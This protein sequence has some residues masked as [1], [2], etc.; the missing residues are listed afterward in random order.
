MWRGAQAL[1]RPRSSADRLGQPAQRE[2]EAG[3]RGF[4]PGRPAYCRSP[5]PRFYPSSSVAFGPGTLAEIRVSQCILSPERGEVVDIK[6]KS[7]Y[8]AICCAATT[9]AEPESSARPRRAPAT[10]ELRGP[11][12]LSGPPAHNHYPKPDCPSLQ[13]GGCGWSGRARNG[14]KI[15]RLKME[16]T[17]MLSGSGFAGAPRIARRAHAAGPGGPC[18]RAGGGVPGAARGVAAPGRDW[19]DAGKAMPAT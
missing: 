5:M 4:P 12:N 18:S 8:D 3:P 7:R 19:T 13:R 6:E 2:S 15:R 14:K 11:P 16:T 17:D 1:R 9:A 10:R